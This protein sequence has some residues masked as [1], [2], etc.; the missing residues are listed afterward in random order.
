MEL[1]LVHPRISIENDMT[2]VSLCYHSAFEELNDDL[3]CDLFENSIVMVME[4][5]DVKGT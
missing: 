3:M 5:V 4:Q 1:L 2:E